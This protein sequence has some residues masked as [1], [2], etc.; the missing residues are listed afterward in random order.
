MKKVKSS[1]KLCIEDALHFEETI[2]TFPSL[3]ITIRGID[4]FIKN[5]GGQEALEGLT[6]T[7]VCEKFLKKETKQTEKSYCEQ[8]KSYNDCNVGKPNAFVSHAWKYNFLKVI[9]SIKQ[10]YE[11]TQMQGGNKLE[12]AV[13][14]VRF[15]FK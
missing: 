7:E 13:I 10:M 12:D 3:G 8:L 9:H 11:K 4:S 6:T 15:I 14:L 5:C 1:K 2:R